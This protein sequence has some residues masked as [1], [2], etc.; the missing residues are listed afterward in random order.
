MTP[1]RVEREVSHGDNPPPQLS[2]QVTSPS[3]RICTVDHDLG[4]NVWGP[5]KG[6]GQV[7]FYSILILFE[8]TK[9]FS[10][11]WGFAQD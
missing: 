1:A 8:E 10:K 7:K 4:V 2:L 3:A 9:D 6:C 11:L 5:S